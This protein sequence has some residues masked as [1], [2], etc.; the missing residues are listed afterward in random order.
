MH[1]L[2]LRSLALAAAFCVTCAP[3]PPQRAVATLTT[4]DIT[5]GLTSDPAIHAVIRDI[6]AERIRATDS[7]LVSFGTRHT[8]SDTLSAARGIG[9]ARRYLFAK[10]SGYSNACGGCLRVEYDPAM[11]QMRG[12][13]DRPLVNVVNV[14]AWLPGR[15]TSRVL[16]MGGHYDSCICART[17]LGPLARF[18]ATQ[19]APG[20]DDDGSGTAAVVE[21][22]R[23]F[24][25]RFPRGLETSVIF[26]AYAGE[27]QGLYGS[28]H[29]AQQLH[30]AGYKIVSAFTDDIVGNVVAEDGTVDSTSVRIFGAEPDNGPSRELARYAWAA[31]TIYN[32]AFQIVP[33]FRLDRIS[34]GGDHSP[35]VGLGDPG[36]RFT[37]RLENYKRQH[38]PTDDFAHVN[39]GY[40]AN[41]A[42]LNASVIGT[43]A[44]APA[45]PVALARRDQASGG[46]RWM[47]TWRP[48]PGAA[49][50]EVL[51]RRTT[52][53][54]YEK[55]YQAGA[56]TSFLLPDQLDDG[57]AAV[58]AVG[59]NGHRSLTS[60]VPPPCPILTTRA[61]SVA[62]GDLIRNCIRP[63]AR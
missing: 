33:V 40:V 16:V 39:F 17:D 55:I 34:R 44:N 5:I 11:L 38:L 6:S 59:A 7:A 57:W 56:G 1:R 41:V 48:S 3:L 8:M 58:R 50:Y 62:A 35:F 43:L 19:D 36:L 9:A 10:L 13:P 27:E 31:G 15:D 2:E 24:S 18:E 51:F 28:T 23:V 21:L 47:L 12:H 37:E 52:A 26:V 60:A 4:S 61:D 54:T 45:P 53:P 14:L 46:A 20:A 49:S 25:E 30:A 32:P 42:R 63:P 22:A 29:L